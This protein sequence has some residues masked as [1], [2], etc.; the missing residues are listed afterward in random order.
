MKELRLTRVSI[1]E[2]ERSDEYASPEAA[3]ESLQTISAKY[4]LPILD[5]LRIVIKESVDSVSIGKDEPHVYFYARK[6]RDSISFRISEG[7]RTIHFEL[8]L[9]GERLESFRLRLG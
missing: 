6:N 9:E 7:N 3:F 4:D 5:V 1:Q 8:P 2:S